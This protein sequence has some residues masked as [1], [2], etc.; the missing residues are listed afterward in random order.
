[1][2]KSSSTLRSISSSD[3]T[4]ML[5]FRAFSTLC[6]HTE[7]CETCAWARQGQSTRMTIWGKLLL[8]SMRP[9]DA[10]VHSTQSIRRRLTEQVS[11]RAYTTLR[12]AHTDMID[13]MIDDMLSGNSCQRHASRQDPPH[14]HGHARRHDTMT[15]THT[16]HMAMQ[17]GK[18]RPCKTRPRKRWPCTRHKNQQGHA[19][20]FRTP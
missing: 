10:S 17:Y 12:T 8:S 1:M 19:R 4:G 2:T 16:F 11:F 15:I 9:L 20:P 14:T 3:L 7:S 5:F 18:T 13:A 6:T